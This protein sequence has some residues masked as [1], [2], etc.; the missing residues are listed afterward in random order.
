MIFIRIHDKNSLND[1]KPEALASGFF[2]AF[3]DKMQGICKP[4]LG[5]VLEPCLGTLSGR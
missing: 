3:V 4:V 1:C 5:R 2:F